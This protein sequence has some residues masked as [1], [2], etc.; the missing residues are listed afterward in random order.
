MCSMNTSSFTM[1]L[2]TDGEDIQAKSPV[3]GA[4]VPDPTSSKTSAG[5][6]TGT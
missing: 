2:S 5:G 4:L 1:G 3:D 6:E